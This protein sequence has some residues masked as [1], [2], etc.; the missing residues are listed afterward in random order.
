M[1]NEHTPQPL[2]PSA[3]PRCYQSHA[4][5]VGHHQDRIIY[6]VP[7]TGI[8]FVTDTGHAYHRLPSLWQRVGEGHP[9]SRRAMAYHAER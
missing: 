1:H 5:I 4:V 3:T 2:T 6:R 9:S 7:A 8:D